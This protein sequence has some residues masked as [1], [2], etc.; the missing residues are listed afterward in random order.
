M[1]QCCVIRASCHLGR[2]RSFGNC[3]RMFNV[4][5]FFQT[6]E[7]RNS[8]SAKQVGGWE[9]EGVAS[10][11]RH[12]GGCVLALLLPNKL[13]WEFNSLSG[14]GLDINSGEGWL[15]I[16][17]RGSTMM[18]AGHSRSRCNYCPHGETSLG[19]YSSRAADAEGSCA[20]CLCTH[21]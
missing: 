13:T 3:K 8:L 21:C 1:S 6:C 12:S 9:V 17:C 11:G 20:R 5:V 18:N 10:G 19:F 16:L 2:S 7:Q 4:V 15:R 14:S